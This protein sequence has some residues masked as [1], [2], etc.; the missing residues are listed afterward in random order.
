MNSTQ[1]S[2]NV[3]DFLPSYDEMNLGAP[4]ILVR[5]CFLNAAGEY[6]SVA[7]ARRGWM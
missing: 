3:Q 6:M 4:N 7:L 5:W 1:I 2:Q